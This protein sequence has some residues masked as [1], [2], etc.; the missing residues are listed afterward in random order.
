MQNNLNNEIVLNTVSNV[1][2]YDVG[3]IEI[4]RNWRK[5]TRELLKKSCYT[6]TYLK[7]ES[8]AL[9]NDSHRMNY[10]VW[11]SEHRKGMHFLKRRGSS[12]KSKRDNNIFNF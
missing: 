1:S 4:L 6:A 3:I 11:S 2:E 12:I 5:A 8:F 7:V 10:I 9:L